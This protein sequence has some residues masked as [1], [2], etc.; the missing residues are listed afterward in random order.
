MIHSAFLILTYILVSVNLI[1]LIK[2]KFGGFGYFFTAVIL[3][4]LGVLITIGFVLVTGSEPNEVIQ[5]ISI[6]VLMVSILL[7]LYL[8]FGA[9]SPCSA[10]GS[11][12]GKLLHAQWLRA[13]E[14]DCP[15]AEK[16]LM[17]CWLGAIFFVFLILVLII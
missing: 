13:F 4:S 14:I 7:P 6:T 17:I 8:V 10:R 3:F 12:L 2:R 16:N 15:L 5:P 1:F 11:E 9:V